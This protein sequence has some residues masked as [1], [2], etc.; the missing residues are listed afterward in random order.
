MKDDLIKLLNEQKKKR[1][2]HKIIT[3]IEAL[4]DEDKKLKKLK[5]SLAKAYSHI[6]EFDKNNRDFRKY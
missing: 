5:L 1:D 2:Y 4:S 6:D 3:T